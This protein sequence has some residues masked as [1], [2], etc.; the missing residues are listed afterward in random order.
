MPR[1]IDLAGQPFGRLTVLERAKNRN[2]RVYWKCKCSCGNITIVHSYNLI[3]GFTKSCGC[4][5]KELTKKSNSTH[6]M[7]NTPEYHIWENMIKRCTNPNTIGWKRYGGRGIKICESWRHDFVAFYNHIGPRPSERHSIDRIDNDRNYEPD[8]VR[9]AIKQE[10]NN[11]RKTNHHI[12]LKGHTLTISEWAKF[13]N[14]NRTTIHQ[15]LKLGWPPAKAIFQK[16]KHCKKY[17]KQ[18]L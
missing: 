11:N 17:H 1:F 14:I 7:S 3:A 12:T 15:R 5:N 18:S 2:G 4:L 13:I 8:N 9:W 6:G 10:Q 16:V